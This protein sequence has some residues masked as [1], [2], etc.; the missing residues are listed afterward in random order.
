MTTLPLRSAGLISPLIHSLVASAGIGLP[1]RTV[2]LA[3]SFGSSSQVQL[4]GNSPAESL[5]TAKAKEQNTI[6]ND[7]FLIMPEWLAESPMAGN[8][9]MSAE[10]GH[11]G[12]G[13]MFVI[14]SE[15]HTSELQSLRHLVCSLLLEKKTNTNSLRLFTHRTF[16]RLA[17]SVLGSVT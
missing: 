1:S 8:R 13:E 2:W 9:N 15:E 5:C 12:A 10:D 6:R 4:S 3:R 7:L 11:H 16:L 17:S 14:R